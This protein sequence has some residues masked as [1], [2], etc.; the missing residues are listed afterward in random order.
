MEIIA[1]I[2]SIVMIVVFLIM[3]SNIAGI[4]KKLTALP[5]DILKGIDENLY[6]GNREVWK[7]NNKQ[8]IEFYLNYLYEL[9]RNQ[10]VHIYGKSNKDSQDVLI[11]R[12]QDLGGLVPVKD[13]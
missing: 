6:F 4:N 1:V 2:L 11:K 8:A 10:T 5:N 7:G 13:I 12:I 3:A 9:K